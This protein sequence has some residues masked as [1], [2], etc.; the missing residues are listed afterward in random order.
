MSYVIVLSS[1]AEKEIDSSF[2]WYEDRLPGLGIRFLEFVEKSILQL[3]L[4]PEF[5]PNKRGKYR[6]I[7]IE[8]F[9]Y[10]IIYGHYNKNCVNIENR[11]S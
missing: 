3:S 6:E 2:N 5:Y 1:H 8:K 11:G 9:P 4:H 7:P 10:L